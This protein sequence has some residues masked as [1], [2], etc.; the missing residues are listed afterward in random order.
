M[1]SP[2]K[3]DSLAEYALTADSFPAFYGKLMAIRFPLAVE[4]VLDLRSL[5]NHT[6]DDVEEPAESPQSREFNESLLA[7]IASF[8]IENKHH[9]ERLLKVLSVLRALHYQH[10]VRSRDTELRIRSALAENREVKSR[11]RRY[12]NFMLLGMT[13][14]AIVW[15]AMTEANWF[16]RMLTFV[17]ALLAWDYYHSLPTLD[18]EMER[19]TKQLNE[20]LRKRVS[21]LNWKTL[22]HKLSLIL[23]YKRIQGIEV[24]RH[25]EEHE[26]VRGPRAYH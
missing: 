15:A 13:A 18:R 23:G 24:F 21:S 22:I 20:L 19:L 4:E 25:R 10:T 11:S 9:S 5:I 6:A 3:S 17:F 7:A 16:I 12:G 8:G 14:S 26:I 1:S 2:A